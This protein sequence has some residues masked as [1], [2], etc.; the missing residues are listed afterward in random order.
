MDLE[1]D[2][3]T[4]EPQSPTAIR[5]DVTKWRHNWATT[6]AR[7]FRIA[8]LE[9]REAV[10]GHRRDN[11]ESF[12]PVPAAKLTRPKLV[13]L[14]GQGMSRQQHSMDSIFGDEA[15]SISEALR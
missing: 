5:H 3:D 6:R 9:S 14:G 10:G 2:M 11:S 8:R 12:V 1:M 15:P 13:V 4:D 7:L